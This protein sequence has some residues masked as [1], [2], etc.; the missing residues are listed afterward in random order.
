MQNATKQLEIW[1]SEFGKDYT[2]RNPA[3]AET[4]DSS[5]ERYYGGVKKSDLFRQFL[6]AERIPSGNVLEVGCNIGAQLRILRTVNPSLELYGIEPQAYALAGARGLSPDINF[7]P[8][9]A[10]DLPFRDGFFEVVMT[11]SVLIHI[12]PSDLPSALLEIYRCSQRFIFCHEYFSESIREVPYHG[13]Q[14]LLWKMNYMQQYLDRF[15]N[16]RIVDVRY[17]HYPD[18]DGEQELVDQVCLLEKTSD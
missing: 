6:S 14:G 9:T 15:P 1:Q 16:L 18:P 7:L 13:H 8:G 4:M 5:L 12:H 11:N 17:L 10:F 2:D 3:S